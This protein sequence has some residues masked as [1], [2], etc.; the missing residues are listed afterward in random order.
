MSNPNDS[1]AK[2]A[3]VE[4]AIVEADRVTSLLQVARCNDGTTNDQLTAAATAATAL[5][6]AIQRASDTA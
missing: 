3:A 4:A 6:A 1:K 2:K 5:G